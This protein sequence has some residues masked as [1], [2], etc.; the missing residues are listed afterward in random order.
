ASRTAAGTLFSRGLHAAETDR[1]GGASECTRDLWHP[2]S[3]P[4]GNIAHYR[5]RPRG[6]KPRTRLLRL[7]APAQRQGGLD[8]ETFRGFRLAGELFLLTSF[9][10]EPKGCWFESCFSLKI[11]GFV[12]V[13]ACALVFCASPAFC[14]SLP[15]TLGDQFCTIT[16]GPTQCTVNE[17]EG[18]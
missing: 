17:G 1:R 10:I 12:S 14:D 16:S 8:A 5:G 15:G 3:R 18:D 9:F 6:A 13:T 4:F 2:V 11:S 7:E